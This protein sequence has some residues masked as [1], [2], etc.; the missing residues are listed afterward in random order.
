MEMNR[1]TLLETVAAVLAA[2]TTLPAAEL[3]PVL[4]N[5][6]HARAETH[7][8]GSQ[9]IYCDG[10]TPGLKSLVVG[11]LVL[12]P[13]QQPHPPH[14]HPDEEILIVTE[15]S[16]QITLNGAASKV[17]AGGVMYVTPN[18]L[19]GIL[20]TGSTPLTFYF[21]KWIAQ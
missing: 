4:L 13:G 12:N 20:N 8:F 15:G 14:T 16:G 1:R 10:A 11:S 18:Y 7:P 19:H 5:A 3:Q 17:E 21:I 9:R 2:S 6:D